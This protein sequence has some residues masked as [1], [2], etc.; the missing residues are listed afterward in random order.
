LDKEVR[1]LVGASRSTPPIPDFA[2]LS[3][4]T[5]DAARPAKAMKKAATRQ[6]GALEHRV[7]INRKRGILTVFANADHQTLVADYLRER[8]R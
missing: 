1:A 2:P 7:V 3:G 4:S 6:R 8:R 5:S